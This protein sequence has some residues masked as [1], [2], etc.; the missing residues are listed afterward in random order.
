MEIAHSRP[1]I[2]YQDLQSVQQRLLTGQLAHGSVVKEF[3]DACAKYLGRRHAI[4]FSSGSAALMHAL[5][6]VGVS[7]GDEVI[8]PTYVCRSVADAVANIGATPILCDIGNG[9]CM[10]SELIES[11]ISERTAA[12]VVV[13]TFGIEV[14]VQEFLNFE[15]PV[16]EDCCQAFSPSFGLYGS[17]AIFSFHATKCLTTGEGGLVVCDSDFIEEEIV[18]YLERTS[19]PSRLSD[20]QAALGLSQLQRYPEMLRRRKLIASIYMKSMPAQLTENL[21][22]F[23]RNSIYFRFPLSIEN[24]FSL[25]QKRF[26]ERGIHVRRGVDELLHRKNGLSDKIFYNSVERYNKTLSVPIYPALEDFEIEKI[27]DAT[28]EIFP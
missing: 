13:H 5:I 14:D 20:F 3:E 21:K 8:I 15:I 10:T 24:D 26:L 9:W 25:L 1:S 2:N 17:A 28:L 27:I 23:A 12:I 6:G 7:D 22:S 19:H 16:V 11:L 18:K 4:S